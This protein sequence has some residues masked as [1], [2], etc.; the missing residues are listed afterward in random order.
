MVSRRTALLG[1]IFLVVLTAIVTWGLAT[2]AYGLRP[3]IRGQL[4]A[5]LHARGGADL[6][7]GLLLIQ[8]RSLR[9]PNTQD[10]NQAALE[11]AVQALGDPYSSYL[12]PSAYQ[13][14]R[15]SAQGQYSGI[16][17]EVD[18]SET[19]RIVV[20]R[21]FPGSPAAT[22]PFQGE[23]PG[24]PVGLEAGD[25]IVSVNGASVASEDKA[26][27]RAKVVGPA[28]SVVLLQV[29]RPGVGLLT[30]RLTR[31]PVA[32]ASVAYR[33]L[34]GGTGYL[35]IQVFNAQTP[36]QVGDALAA[37]HTAGMR[38]LVLDLRDNPGGVLT[39]AV[40]VAGFLLPPGVV[41]YLQ[42][43]GG[44]RQALRLT[45]VHPLGV[46]FAVL[47]NGYTASAAELLAGAVQDDHRAPLVGER[48]FGKAVVQQIFP[49]A[50]G[51]ALR[52]TVARYL[53]PKGRDING[54][55]LTPDDVVP[56]PNATVQAMGNPA[57]DPQLAQA[58]RILTGSAAA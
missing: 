47:V 2:G 26:T 23:P 7:Q 24:Q 30:F 56:F 41:T 34:P 18:S 27:V 5:L 42:P 54:S 25:V 55:G 44:A 22:T 12:S 35:E 8:N 15:N 52:L 9:A 17:I 13:A 28:G 45:S 40:Q 48:T 14:L 11:G 50:G 53:T 36:A 43:R 20:F 38:R 33:E 57:T 4:N 29:D 37:L 3:G 16:G 39:S 21:V 1:G 32:L 51:G 10:V 49:L 46:P 19:G 31:R 58:I 6:V